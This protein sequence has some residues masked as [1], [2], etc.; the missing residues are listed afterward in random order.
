MKVKSIITLPVMAALVFGSPLA[1][2]HAET[3]TSTPANPPDPEKFVRNYET[4]GK[5]CVMTEK[6]FE[7]KF[8]KKGKKSELKQ[9]KKE[10]K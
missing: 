2:V 4:K 5:N 9:K 8:R 3:G 7:H 1:L 6:K 10:K